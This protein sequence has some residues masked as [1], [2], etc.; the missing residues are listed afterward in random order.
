MATAPKKKA[1][2]AVAEAEAPAIR[3]R[4]LEFR[5]VP[6]AELEENEK[7][8]RTHPHAQR[9][10][11][12]EVLERVGIAGA[13]IAYY[14][15]RNGGKLTLID[16]PARRLDHETDWPTLILD[17]NDEEADL[18][19]LTY[20]PLTGLAETDEAAL[21]ALAET[22]KTG[23]P[24]LEDLVQRLKPSA[25]A[26]AEAIAEVEEKV[27]IAAG[28]PEMELQAFEH[29]DYIVCL[30]RSSQDWMQAVERF[31][32]EK[33]AFTLRDGENRK[34]GLGRVV[35]GSKVLEMLRDE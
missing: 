7:N 14:S 19:L 28:P 1:A 32:L 20:D 5:R 4:I 26:E 13:L 22:V 29:Y 3:D 24:G 21:R 31:G 8:W 10:A 12:A 17:V 33:Q 11:L 15:D 6:A 30:F 35:D 34:V 23:T 2:V 9:S 18:L 16:G 25:V 27:E